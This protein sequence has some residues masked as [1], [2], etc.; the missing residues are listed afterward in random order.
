MI[1]RLSPEGCCS[2]LVTLLGKHE[3]TMR[4]RTRPARVE[5]S[6][7]AGMWRGRRSRI[8]AGL[9]PVA[10]VVGTLA[11][12]GGESASGA[13][14][15]GLPTLSAI[16]V[17]AL[18]GLDRPGADAA[19]TATGLLSNGTLQTIT[20]EL[21]W[22]TSSPGSVASVSPSGLANGLSPG[23]E[24]ITATA[25][26]GLLGLLSPITGTALLTALP[27]LSTITVSPAVTSLAQGQT[28]QFTATGLF[29][30]GTVHRITNDLSWSSAS[31]A[32]ASVS[33]TGLATGLLPGLDT[34]TA[35][36]PAGLTT[37]PLAGLVSPL[38]GATDQLALNP[39]APPPPSLTMTPTSGKKKSVVSALGSNFPPGGSVVVT[40]LSGLK[41]PT[42][43]ARCCVRQSSPQPGP[44]PATE[45]F[46]R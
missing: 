28:Q 7:G 45:P 18:H 14:L 17:V 20:S 23:V 8:V 44:S 38:S 27:V 37:G 12:L 10:V 46:R 33:N 41:N 4:F 19:F 26:A 1:T 34:I 16:H 32:L 43:P 31:G 40:Y 30:D 3:K 9:L 29:S 2:K 11:T 36:A 39:P 25:P 5:R 21:T 6:Q 22:A 24:S 42:A 35:T 13:G 15:P